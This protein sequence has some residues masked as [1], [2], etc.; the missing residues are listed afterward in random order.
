MNICTQ[1]F[2]SL[3][4]WLDGQATPE[5]S[6][7][8]EAHLAQ[9]PD[10]QARVQAMKAFPPQLQAAEEFP[11]GRQFARLTAE[12]IKARVSPPRTGSGS[13]WRA[14]YRRLRDNPVAHLVGAQRKRRFR[15]G[16][17]EMLKAVGIFALPALVMALLQENYALMG[18]LMCS[19]AGLMVGLPLRQFGEEV[20]L[21]SALRRGRCLEEILATGVDSRA[22]L[23]GL[24]YQGLA[25]VARASLTVMPVLMLGSLALPQEVQSQA[26]CLEL[27]WL[28][29]LL[30]LFVAGYYLAQ[31]LLVWPGGWPQRVA[32]ASALLLPAVGLGYGL[33]WPGVW[34]ACLGVGLGARH[35]AIQGLQKEQQ[36]KAAARLKRNQLVRALSQNPIARREFTRLSGGLAGKNPVGSLVAWRAGSVLLPLIW[37]I[38]AVQDAY[39]NSFTYWVGAMLFAA[40]F[41]VRAALRCLPAV[42]RER[43]QQTWETLLQ[44]PLGIPSF[45]SGWL[46]VC[47]YTTF[48]EGAVAIS[49]LTLF[50]L[51]NQFSAGQLALVGLSLAGASLLGGYVGL[52]ISASSRSTRQAQQRLLSLTSLAVMGWLV[53][54]GLLAAVPLFANLGQGEFWVDYVQLQAP[55]AALALVGLVLAGRARPQL[56]NLHQLELIDETPSP[57]AYPLSLLPLDLASLGLLGY[58]VAFWRILAEGTDVDPLAGS[59]GLLLASLI[60]LGLIRLPLASLAELLRGTALS[61]VVGAFSGL[62]LCFS[63]AL[64]TSTW[65]L[66]RNFSHDLGSLIF[67]GLFALALGCGISAYRQARVNGERALALARRTLVS[68]LG[69]TCLAAAGWPTYQS[70]LLRGHQASSELDNLRIR[71][72]QARIRAENSLPRV[73]EIYYPSLKIQ[74]RPSE[75]RQELKRSDVQRSLKAFHSLETRLPRIPSAEVSFWYRRPVQEHYLLQGLDFEDRHD[76][77]QALQSYLTSLNWSTLTGQSMALN[78]LQNLLANSQSLRAQDYRAALQE[79]P[80][81]DNR[82]S[83]E[84]RVNFDWLIW[85]GAS[86]LS[87]NFVEQ[88]L[89]NGSLC[90]VFVPSLL[91]NLEKARLLDKRQEYL[92]LMT[93]EHMADLRKLPGDFWRQGL[94]F[95]DYDASGSFPHIAAELNRREGT[96]LIAALQLYRLEH[97]QWPSDLKQVE[98]YLKR[99]VRNYL[100]KEELFHYQ[101]SQ[102]QPQLRLGEQVLMPAPSDL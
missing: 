41:F 13:G 7:Q 65:Q 74:A 45:V 70:A 9:C 90:T 40:L 80:L 36:P 47:L 38:W 22:L 95:V 6:R 49:M 46:Q 15:F 10:C 86:S 5:E 78:R 25:Q 26:Y 54:W 67:V 84:L 64:T 88:R 35:L 23:D 61:V 82:L 21:L 27:A 102:G 20:A 32:V 55:F 11:L 19:A 17:Q 93:A 2:E 87:H 1:H 43:E 76:H 91:L 48:S 89:G 18:F 3:S 33:G 94:F 59:L 29:S 58:G 50:G 83:S 101:G 28:P 52:G 71:I 57:S 75:L 96:A 92:P 44:T 79:I 31:F 34:L 98:G 14:A 37:G 8:V 77:S 56:T 97:G 60:W 85:S 16:R 42:P 51:I 39:S 30:L 53:G 66:Q 24:A 68:L 99:P 81:D 12:K 100:G 4:A 73:Y 69:L 63:A 62:A 72:D